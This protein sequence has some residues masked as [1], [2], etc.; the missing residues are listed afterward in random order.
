MT[1]QEEKQK[2]IDEVIASAKERIDDILQGD[3]PALEKNM[4]AAIEA[5][6]TMFQVEAIAAEP[7]PKYQSGTN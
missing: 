5:R 6:M 4:K 2:R 1:H 3:L 7:T